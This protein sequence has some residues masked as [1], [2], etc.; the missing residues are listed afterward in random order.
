M[1]ITLVPTSS[2]A[3]VPWYAAVGDGKTGARAGSSSM[4]LVLLSEGQRGAHRQLRV[5]GAELRNPKFGL[6]PCAREATCLAL[7]AAA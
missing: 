7:L 1:G 5:P 3:Q 4:Q 6:R 2:Q